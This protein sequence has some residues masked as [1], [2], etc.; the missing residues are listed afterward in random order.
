MAYHTFKRNTCLHANISKQNRDLGRDYRL[1]K[2]QDKLKHNLVTH[3][4]Y[5]LCTVAI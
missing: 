3:F 1:L 2:Q 5:V 4:S